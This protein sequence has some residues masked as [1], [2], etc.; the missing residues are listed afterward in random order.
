[1]F[2]GHNWFIVLIRCWTE[3]FSV[4]TWSFIQFQY[5]INTLQISKFLPGT[6]RCPMRF[7]ECLPKDAPLLY[8]L[9]IIKTAKLH[10]LFIYWSICFLIRAVTMSQICFEFLLVSLT[11]HKVLLFIPNVFLVAFTL[12]V[13]NWLDHK[14]GMPAAAAVEA[15][16]IWNEWEEYCF[17]FIPFSLTAFLITLRILLH[18]LGTLPFLCLCGG[19]ERDVD[20]AR[21]LFSAWTGQMLWWVGAISR[22]TPSRNGSVFHAFILS[23]CVPF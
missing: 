11:P 14:S 2:C 1:M 7:I 4:A 21:Y 8:Y 22:V 12:P 6:I 10:S 18:M 9:G 3:F 23:K 15:A 16:P 17:G 19:P 20:L 5:I 13:S